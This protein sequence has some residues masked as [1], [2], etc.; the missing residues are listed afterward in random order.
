MTVRQHPGGPLQE[1]PEEAPDIALM[2]R[3]QVGDVEAF[4]T[5]VERYWRLTVLYAQSVGGMDRGPDIAQEA[6]ARLWQRREQWELGGG[7]R[8]WLLRTARNL[9]IGEA[10]KDAV[11]LRWVESGDPTDNS[12]VTPL[13]EA[14]RAELRSAIKSAV[15]ALSPRR[16]EVFTLFYLQDLSYKETAEVMNIRQ[17]SVAN[18]LQ[19]AIADLR[20][21]LAPFFPGLEGRQ[22]PARGTPR[23]AGSEGRFSVDV[24]GA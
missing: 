24:K 11:R 15:E 2:R 7:V 19:A 14:E 10:R 9:A 13:Q 20:Q 4:S 3:V 17:Q 5:L 12:Q 6:F 16:R 1:G 22:V 21:S 23:G 8:V 18:Y